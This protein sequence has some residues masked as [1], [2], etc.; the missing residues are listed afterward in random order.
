MGKFECE[1]CGRSVTEAIKLRVT[2]SPT[3]AATPAPSLSRGKRHAVEILG[4][5]VIAAVLVLIL[6]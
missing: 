6:Q 4:E 1:T 3:L 2:S 5:V